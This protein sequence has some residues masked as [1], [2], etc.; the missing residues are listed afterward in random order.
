MYSF[1]RDRHGA[2]AVLKVAKKS[3]IIIYDKYWE[4]YQR[5]R[6]TDQ[7]RLSWQD[8]QYKLYDLALIKTITRSMFGDYEVRPREK[9]YNRYEFFIT[10]KVY[11]IYSRYERL[12]GASKI[13]LLNRIS[14]ISKRLIIKSTIGVARM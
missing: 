5:F 7:S 6:N 9:E 8:K 12:I 3:D 4:G 11:T 14:L 10:L 13:S 1:G 2:S